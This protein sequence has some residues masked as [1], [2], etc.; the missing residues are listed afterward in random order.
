MQSSTLNMFK[1]NFIVYFKH[2]NKILN[3]LCE[4][5]IYKLKYREKLKEE[6][7]YNHKKSWSFNLKNKMNRLKIIISVSQNHDHNKTIAISV[8][9]WTCFIASMDNYESDETPSHGR[10]CISF[11]HVYSQLWIFQLLLQSFSLNPCYCF[12]LEVKLWSPP[13]PLNQGIPQYYYLF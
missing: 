9:N 7:H 3:P 5:N 4:N 2:I 1:I 6:H 13:Q 11:S 10:P 8:L 12:N